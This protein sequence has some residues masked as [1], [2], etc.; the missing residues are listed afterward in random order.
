MINIL[1]YNELFE[2]K[3]WYKTIP[4]IISWLESKSDMTW[5]WLDT[6]TTGLGGP[7]KQQLT[8]V[9]A[10]AT[11]WNKSTNN[12]K[13]LDSFDEKIK[14]NDETKSKFDKEEDNTKWVLSFN[15]YGSSIYKYK[16]KQKII[17]DFISWIDTFDNPFLIAQNAKFDMAMLGGRFGNKIKGEVFDTKELIQSY[18]L[19]AL[20][21]LS[22]KDNKFK[23][24][25]NFIGN[26]DRD[27]G[28]ISSSMSKVGPS[29]GI[30][31]SGY[32]DALTDCKITI[33]MFRKIYDFL[34]K[35]KD[36]DISKYQIDRIKSI[37]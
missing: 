9:S 22:E 18:Y 4:Q 35:N 33:E 2:N 23:E 27:N 37:K 20:Q 19:P 26:S 30:D 7:R 16:N 36:I 1:R 5:I 31:M 28:L 10:I 3:M 25:V 15:H 24:I 6:E 11:K 34:N 21:K 17:N 32:H 29:L 8:Q 14:L 12:F 13:E